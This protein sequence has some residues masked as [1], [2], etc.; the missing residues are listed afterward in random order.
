MLLSYGS[1]HFGGALSIVEMLVVLYGG[2]M[3]VNPQDPLWPGRD[4]FILSKGHAGPALYATLALKGFFPVEELLTLNANGTNLPSHPDRNLVRGVDMTTG[5]LGQGIGVAAGLAK[6]IKMEAQPNR[7]F[8]IVGDGE[9]NEGQCWEAFAFAAHHRLD[10]LIVLIDNNKKQ[11]DGRTCEICDSFDL[12]AKM[13]AFGFRCISA[14]GTDVDAI[15]FAL[16]TALQKQSAPTAIV[17]N[18]VKGQGIKWM[19]ELERNHH[20]RLN[21]EQKKALEEYVM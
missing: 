18:T 14:D 8:C 19:E 11:L 16:D 12:T 13:S 10:N 7:V 3:N 17:V 21:Q 20:I 1:G 4:Y 6:A 9:L 15:T 5:S 2:V